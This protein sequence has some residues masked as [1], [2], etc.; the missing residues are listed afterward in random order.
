MS[1]DPNLTERDY[2]LLS[3]YL[4]GMLEAEER[5]A[6]EARLQ[7]EPA[8]R[9]ELHALRQTVALLN[10]LPPLKAPRDFTLRPGMSG[11]E[12]RP[13]PAPRKKIISYPWLSGLS[14]VAALVCLVLGASLLL[15]ELRD[16]PA[17]LDR[18]EVAAL[19]TEQPATG[20]AILS[21]PVEQPEPAEVPEA[22]EADEVIEPLAMPE[23]DAP[24][25]DTVDEAED[26]ALEM[27]MF[28]DDGAL[29][30]AP[31]DDDLSEVGAMR[32]PEPSPMPGIAAMEP[33]PA[34]QTQTARQA[35]ETFDIDVEAPAEE[36]VEIEAEADA[37]EP[38]P[39]ILGEEPAAVM[40]EDEP[41]G[42]TVPVAVALIAFG[43]ALAGVTIWLALK[44]RLKRS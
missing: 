6:L 43:L 3:E 4:D 41:A 5:S 14:A 38:E 34:M 8:L 16:D 15:G 11:V 22:A 32:L 10:E 35:L 20:P 18:D 29:P 13:Q 39:E 30:E 36:A 25:V 1:A 27:R 33:P 17:A 28:P 21:A 37:V 40:A 9:R 19:A 42:D 23:A 44:S 2:Q 7:I 12:I 26:P 31:S 24:P